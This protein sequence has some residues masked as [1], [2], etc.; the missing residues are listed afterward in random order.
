M[1]IGYTHRKAE[2][3][4]ESEEK[5][6]L[7]IRLPLKVITL[8]GFNLMSV[9][10][11]NGQGWQDR[12]RHDLGITSLMALRC[13]MLY[14]DR[15]LLDIMDIIDGAPDAN[16]QLRERYDVARVPGRGIVSL[17]EFD[18]LFSA[19]TIFIRRAYRDRISAAMQ[20]LRESK[21]E[22]E[23]TSLDGE[24]LRE[25]VDESLFLWDNQ[26]AATIIKSMDAMCH[27]DP[28][29]DN[30]DHELESQVR[31]DRA[32]TDLTIALRRATDSR[33]AATYT[34][35]F[36]KKLVGLAGLTFQELQQKGWSRYQRDGLLP[37]PHGS[38][39]QIG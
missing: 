6:S 37:L 28:I 19:E 39:F 22:V 38:R 12:W 4:D 23:S 34:L 13:P 8:H 24:P 14:S 10:A 33:T 11:N 7:T 36:C 9:G 2:I 3:G 29:P 32:W 20:R 15:F 31:D 17:T 5:R 35:E 1:H 26:G 21:F 30:I 25:P 18:G 16:R 27:I